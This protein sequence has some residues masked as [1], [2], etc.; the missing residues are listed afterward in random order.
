MN[1]LE[2]DGTGQPTGRL[3]HDSTK[4]RQ[5]LLP[6][7]F[8]VL[9]NECM[10]AELDQAI[11]RRQS[12]FLKRNQFVT[13]M[14]A[15][16]QTTY[17]AKVN[18]LNQLLSLVE[19]HF[20]SLDTVYNPPGGPA[21]GVTS[22]KTVMATRVAGLGSRF[23]GA[24][25]ILEGGGEKQLH[26]TNSSTVMTR[27]DPASGQIVDIRDPAAVTLSQETI[28]ISE[29]DELRN[30]NI[31]NQMRRQ[32]ITV[33]LM[34]E[35]LG[36]SLFNL[37]VPNLSATWANDLKAI[38]LEVRCLQVQFIETF[39]TP[40]LSG[41]VCAV[42]K[43]AGDNVRAGEPVIRIEDDT[44]ILLAGQ[45]KC[46]APL[47]IGQSCTIETNNVFATNPAVAL[48]LNAPVAAIRG[49]DSETDRWN[50][51]LAAQ[52]TGA[53]RLPLGYEFEPHPDFSK[54][55]FA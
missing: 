25:H 38:D 51:V 52:N 53:I 16:V 30:P 2:L 27:F 17:P 4:L 42:Q 45:V 55:T 35:I 32:R 31:E 43:D 6:L 9:S 28:S 5:T 12:Q 49:Y 3:T 20:Q 19:Q 36:E 10:A 44:Q 26:N 18:K 24:T 40:R 22:P 33:D 41:T 39:L 14:Q 23:E 34:D 29:N 11:L 21:A 46:R 7:A 8:C 37:T 13:Q 48:S 1:D 50:L 15:L 47:R 54:I